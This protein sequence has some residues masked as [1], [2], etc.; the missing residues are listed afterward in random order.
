MNLPSVPYKTLS[1]IV[2]FLF[3]VRAMAASPVVESFGTGSNGWSGTGSGDG[4]NVAGIWSFTSGYASLLFKNMGFP[5]T[6][7]GGTLSNSPAASSGSFTGD[8]PQAGI[9][10][11]GFSFYAAQVVPAAGYAILEWG[12]STSIYQRGFTVG[13]TGVWYEFKASLADEAAGSWTV[14]QGSVDDFSSARQSVKFVR[15]RVNRNGIPQHEFR[16]D[17]V[18]LEGEPDATTLDLG[19]GLFS[20][21]WDA[22]HTG[23]TYHVESSPEVTGTWSVAQSFV[24]T[25]VQHLITLTNVGDMLYWRFVRP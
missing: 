24:A 12:G 3:S 23:K 15:I 5:N 22:L 21:I 8:Y 7:G 2:L 1:L 20:S 17:D 18:Y 6:G 16:V 19:G 13:T 4:F 10:L 11:V 25:N 9:N 14:L